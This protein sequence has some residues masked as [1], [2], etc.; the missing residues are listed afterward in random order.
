MRFPSP[1]GVLTFY[2]EIDEMNERIEELV[3]VPYRGS[4]FLI[5]EQKIWTLVTKYVS[6]PYRGSYFLILNPLKH[7]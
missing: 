6:V 7:S 5:I 2:I 3:S 1:I 4:Y